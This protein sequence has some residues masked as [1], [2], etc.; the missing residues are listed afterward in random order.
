MT[1]KEFIQIC[2]ESNSM[3]EAAKRIGMTYTEFKVKAL[4]L[5]CYDVSKGKKR[6]TIIDSYDKLQEILDGKH[7]TFQP[8]KLKNLLFKHGLKKNQCEICGIT[9]WNGKPINCQLDH[10][11]GNKYNQSLENLR[12]ICP[13]C[14][15][16]TE[17][18]GYKKGRKYNKD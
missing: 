4:A 1:D 15:S 2:E 5:K 18:F 9:E 12:I 17:T 3:A 13:N 6:R 11:D 8:F 7:P 16:Q 14:H 10:I